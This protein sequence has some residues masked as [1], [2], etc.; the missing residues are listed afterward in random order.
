MRQTIF[1]LAFALTLVSCKTTDFQSYATP[2]NVRIA[3]A[4]ICS[5]TLNF[6]VKDTDRVQVA[7]YIYSVAHGIRTLST[8][9]VPSPT[10]LAATV[11]LFTT[12]GAKWTSLGTSIS[13][14]YGG[15]YAN[16]KGNPKLCLE[17]LEAIASGCE[18]ASNA[19]LPAKPSA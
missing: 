14:V 10:D 1:S 13:S 12:Q 9:A 7:N 19:Y 3:T 17:Y 15:I 4:L 6:A 11:S 5:N 18:D 8:G 16:I 2:T